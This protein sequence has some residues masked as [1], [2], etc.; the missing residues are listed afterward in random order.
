MTTAAAAAAAKTATS[1]SSS[2]SSAD[3]TYHCT[4]YLRVIWPCKAMSH[5]SHMAVT[6]FTGYMLLN[7]VP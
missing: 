1:S 5:C 7:I 2:S 4:A 3:R 6:V